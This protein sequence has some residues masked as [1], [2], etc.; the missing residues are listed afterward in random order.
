[1][2]LAIRAWFRGDG[3]GSAALLSESGFTGLAGFSGFRFSH[4]AL[5]L[6]TG[7][8]A[9][10]WQGF[11]NWRGFVRIR[12]YGIGGIF[13]ISILSSRAFRIEENPAK[14][15]VDERLSIKDELA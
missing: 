3:L 6:I 15:N 1:M 13:R 10:E 9:N 8:P 7:N 4:L 2:S 12:I 11:A 14:T 5:F